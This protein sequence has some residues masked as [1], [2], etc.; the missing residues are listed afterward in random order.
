MISTATATRALPTK[1][2][3]LDGD[4][5]PREVID[6]EVVGEYAE[7]LQAG[8]TLPP[9]VVFHDGKHYWLGDGFHRYHGHT[10][11]GLD[12]IECEIRP[13]TV[14]D[15]QWYSFAANQQ[16]GLRR[17]NEDKRIAVVGALQHVTG[18]TM[19]NRAIAEHC[20]VSDN[21]VGQVRR[22]LEGSGQVARVESRKGRDGRTQSTAGIGGRPLPSVRSGPQREK[23]APQPARQPVEEPLSAEESDDDYEARMDVS[24]AAE[25]ESENSAIDKINVIVDQ[26]GHDIP[27]RLQAVFTSSR[28]F[29]DAADHIRKAKK[30]LLNLADSDAG[31]YVDRAAVKVDVGNLLN[32][33]KA[34]RPYTVCPHCQGKGCKQCNGQ[35]WMHKQLYD[36]QTK[37]TKDSWGTPF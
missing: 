34:K 25:L 26:L 31:Q 30:I 36:L 9:V 33:S 37:E 20:G 17:T 18:R 6:M 7:A 23:A 3:R 24:C 10:R 11:A 27:E 2:V 16:H 35:G 28:A 19:S 21:F 8:A 4:T 5:Q 13:G 1:A 32:E 12:E 22:E 29:D 14:A 15:A